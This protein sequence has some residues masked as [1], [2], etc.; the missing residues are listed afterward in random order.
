MSRGLPNFTDALRRPSGNQA[1]DTRDLAPP[2]NLKKVKIEALDIAFKRELTELLL[3]PTS[4]TE[5][6]AANWIRQQVPG[7]SDPLLQWINGGERVVSFTALV[8]RDLAENPTLN[9]TTTTETYGLIET[10]ATAAGLEILSQVSSNNALILEQLAESG[11][12]FLNFN[13]A[14]ELLNVQTDTI[15]TT[16]LKSVQPH[17]D[18]YRSLLMPRKSS[19]R[20]QSKTPPLV[21]LDMGDILG[22][23]KIATQHRWVMLQ[24]DFNIT[25]FTPDLQP[26]EAQVQFTFIEYVDRSKTIDAEAINATLDSQSAKFVDTKVANQTAEFINRDTKKQSLNKFF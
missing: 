15:S 19:R 16:W 20:F 22:S 21:R 3:N 18:Y 5:T 6:K 25:K 24:Y 17:L 12:P 11:A 2:K 8:T 14:P 4:I 9:Q 1:S 7:Q 23:N 13:V 10:E 26:I